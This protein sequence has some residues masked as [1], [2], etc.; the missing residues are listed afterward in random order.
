MYKKLAVVIYLYTWEVE[1]GVV[2]HSQTQ[3][4]FKTA[5]EAGNLPQKIGYKHQM[6][7]MI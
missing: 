5:W 7:A 1:V 4:Y 2:S 3:S 6:K